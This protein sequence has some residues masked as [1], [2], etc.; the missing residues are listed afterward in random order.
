MTIYQVSHSLGLGTMMMMMI[1]II[2][3]MMIMIMI[4]MMFAGLTA[5]GWAAALCGFPPL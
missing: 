1:M 2:M 3:M 4:M 5:P